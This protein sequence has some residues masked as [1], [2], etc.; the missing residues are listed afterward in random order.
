MTVAIILQPAAFMGQI[1]F[2]PKQ[3]LIQQ[4]LN[5]LPI[6]PTALCMV[7]MRLRNG[8]R[9]VHDL[10]SGTRVVM[11]RPAGLHA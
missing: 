4:I 7:T 3:M 9:G 10:A 2:D 8:Y 1:T 5:L 6:V 11:L